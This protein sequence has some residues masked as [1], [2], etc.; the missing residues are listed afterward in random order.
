MTTQALTRFNVGTLAKDMPDYLKEHIG[1]HDG[2][3]GTGIDDILVPR[4]GLAQAGM[5]PQLKEDSDL[6]I[7]ELKAGQLFNTVTNEIYGK[8]VIAVPL[9]FFKNWVQ[10]KQGGGVEKMFSNVKDVLAADLQFQ[11]DGKPPKV[12]EYK[13]RLSLL[14]AEGKP[15]EPIIVGFKSSGLKTAK[16]WQSLINQAN[17]PSFARSYKFTVVKKRKGSQDWFG[18]DVLPDLFVPA[19]F[20]A[21]AKNQFD[22]F[23][24]SGFKVDER[25]TADDGGEG[26]GHETGNE[27]GSTD[28]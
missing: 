24:Q 28:F 2:S 10:Y 22:S 27:K 18:V 19:E 4:L 11:G 8:E 6:F 9:I 13:N 21:Y 16:K 5:S 20:F 23:T 26:D 3:A 12:T 14:V 1:Q 17:L 25:G 15:V 7:P